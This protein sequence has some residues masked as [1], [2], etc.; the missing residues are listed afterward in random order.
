M[1]VAIAIVSNSKSSDSSLAV[2]STETNNL[3]KYTAVLEAL[4]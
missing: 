3:H 1:Q 2:P 4:F